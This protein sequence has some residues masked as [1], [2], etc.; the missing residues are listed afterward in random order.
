MINTRQ[1]LGAIRDALVADASLT[2]VV[3]AESIRTHLKD[4]TDSTDF[5]HI[6]MAIDAED[7]G[8]KGMT[9]YGMT[10]TLELWSDYRGETEVW[11]INDLIAA[12][13]DRTPPAIASGTI[14]FLKFSGIDVVTEDDGRTRQGTITY[15]LFVTE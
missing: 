15:N 11:Q 8:V 10:L 7:A 13:I 3:P 4:G 5:P 9:A 14:S 1:V 6:L 12:V 2:A